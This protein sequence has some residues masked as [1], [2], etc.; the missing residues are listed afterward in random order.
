MDQLNSV[1]EPFRTVLRKNFQ[2]I[3]TGGA[4]YSDEIPGK[5]IL[6]GVGVV[7]VGPNGVDNKAEILN[8]ARAFAIKEI[9]M[10]V[11]GATVNSVSTNSEEGQ[12]G[13]VNGVEEGNVIT[14]WRDLIELRASGHQISPPTVGSFR[15][16][17][18]TVQV[19]VLGKIF[20]NHDEQLDK[21]GLKK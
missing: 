11:K 10:Y 13:V 12:V 20:E 18:G 19:V 7:D 9:V 15:T 16:K 21:N 5:R 17:S 1:N 8:V 2:L 4:I 3:E 14:K 6:I